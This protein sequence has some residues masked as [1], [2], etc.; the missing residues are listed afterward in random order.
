M[1]HNIRLLAATPLARFPKIV[2]F[3]FSPFGK[4]VIEFK[5][6]WFGRGGGG[7]GAA[8]VIQTRGHEKLHT[9]TEIREEGGSGRPHRSFEIR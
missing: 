7:G 1:V 4:F 3:V 8:V 5:Q 9:F 6:D 2:T